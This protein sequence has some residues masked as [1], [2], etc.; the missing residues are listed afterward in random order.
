MANE[1]VG[2]QF[3]QEAKLYYLAAASSSSEF[4][5]LY[6]KAVALYR[7]YRYETAAKV[8]Q[9]LIEIDPR[10]IQGLHLVSDI[11]LEILE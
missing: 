3:F 1:E 4:I 5:P 2:T 8:F 9:K 6:N 11:W 7:L 10:F